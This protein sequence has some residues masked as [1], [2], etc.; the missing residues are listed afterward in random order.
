M[1]TEH[2]LISLL[3]GCLTCAP[4]L[5]NMP[6]GEKVRKAV[7]QFNRAQALGFDST[8]AMLEHQNWLKRNGT[9]EYKRWLATVLPADEPETQSGEQHG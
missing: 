1:A 3:E 6:I 7:E 9:P 5:S 2:Q 4:Q 8:A